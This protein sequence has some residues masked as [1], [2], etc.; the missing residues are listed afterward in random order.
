MAKAVAHI[1]AVELS[2]GEFSATISKVGARFRTTSENW[3]SIDVGSLDD[4]LKFVE[5]AKYIQDQPWEE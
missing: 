2:S 5:E 4:F 1:D 3:N